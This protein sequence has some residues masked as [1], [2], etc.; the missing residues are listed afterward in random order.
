M[1]EPQYSYGSITLLLLFILFFPQLSNVFG[2]MF[3]RNESQ[4]IK[5]EHSPAAHTSLS[6][7]S[8]SREKARQFLESQYVQEAGL[9]RA[10]VTAKPDMERVYVAS[11]NLLAA[12]ALMLLRSPLGKSIL[13]KLA[14]NYGYGFNKRHE[15]I[16]GFD[17][18]DEFYVLED[19]KIGEVYSKEFGTT[20]ELRYE[21]P[22]Q[23]RV[24]TDWHSYADLLVYRALDQIIAGR[25][26]EAKELSGLLLTLWD[27]YGFNDKTHDVD[28]LKRYETYKVALALLLCRVL[29]ELNQECGATREL[30][31]MW[32]SILARMQ[33]SDGGVVTHYVVREGIIEPYGDA[34]TETTSIATLSLSELPSIFR[35]ESKL[36]LMQL[37]VTTDSDWTSVKI[38]SGPRVID[39]NGSI[40]VGFDAHDLKYSFSESHIWISKKQFDTTTVTFKMLSL[41][42]KGSELGRIIINKGHMGSTQVT[43]RLWDGEQFAHFITLKHAGVNWTEPKANP[44]FFTVNYSDLYAKPSTTAFYEPAPPSLRKKVCAFYY[45]WYGNPFGP[46]RMLSHW[47]NIA[48]DS[49]ASSAHYPLLGPY[50]SYDE[51]VIETHILMAKAAGIDCFIVSWWGP[52]S[53]EDSALRHIINVS[54]RVGFNITI[55]YE[56][57]REW[58]PLTRHEDVVYELSYLVKKYASSSSFLK[59]GSKPVLFIYNVDGHGRGVE[60]WLKVRQNLER[61]VGRVYIIG[62]LRS[63]FYLSVFDGFHTYNELNLTVMKDTFNFYKQQMR[64]GLAGID[65][66]QATSLVILRGNPTIQEKILG[67][68]VTP[69]YDDR[70]VRK[71]G[72]YLDRK[73][74][75]TYKSYW[76]SALEANPD[77]ILV[78]SWNE[79]HEGTEVEPSREYGFSYIQLTAEYAITFKGM[80]AVP[81]EAPTLQAEY[82]LSS[83]GRTLILKMTTNSTALIV[84]PEIPLQSS[85]HPMHMENYL[86]FTT[87]GDGFDV[88]G[89]IFP[90]LK[91][92]ETLE[93]RLKL[94]GL[95]PETITIPISHITYYST[96][97][98]KLVLKTVQERFNRLTI[99]SLEN[100]SIT[101]QATTHSL[102]DGNVSLWFREKTNVS[103]STKAIW[104]P[105]DFE[106]KKLTSYIVNG[107]EF[108]VHEPKEEFTLTITMYRPIEIEFRYMT[109]YYVWYK[110]VP[111]NIIN[112]IEAS[113]RESIRGGFFPSNKTIKI[114]LPPTLAVGNSTKYVFLNM[115]LELCIPSN[116]IEFTL[117]KPMTV[118]ITYTRMVR[119]DIFSEYGTVEGGGW[120]ETGSDVRISILPTETGFLIRKVFDHWE[121]EKGLPISSQPVIYIREIDKPVKFTAIWRTDYS[122]L[123]LLSITVAFI[124]LTSLAVKKRSRGRPA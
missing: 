92:G 44:R 11:D 103:V 111:E 94:T 86:T 21:K 45:P 7:Y 68:T 110:I 38:L 17:I 3:P 85:L 13:E 97:G 123:I 70:K 33:R 4:I 56:S 113:L 32:L 24:L 122:Q 109:E 14:V 66:N 71:P 63:Q 83:D 18:P 75:D 15:V 101:L 61:L 87:K 106:R 89:R 80:T 124:I 16:L 20:F 27:G 58:Q 30:L 107:K 90:L 48:A 118:T 52:G 35:P 117:N 29:T 25:V 96:D 79:W 98:R 59:A 6:I 22:N 116:E 46:S 36:Y 55:Y 121:D 53:F 81:I 5:V 10:A 49:I 23:S 2:T 84:T 76:N 114:T 119:V 91:P 88:M 62:D 69:G 39:Y 57:F 93:L 31:D 73:E 43:I 64:L 40:S 72:S 9:L 28:V 67:F 12:R 8:F 104:N 112:E 47:S 120:Y 100:S 41:A 1:A 19:E 77:I 74:G 51:R 78:T 105:N 37:E 82:L 102:K 95:L 26:K 34:N 65:L 99:K 50:D 54:E 115:C 60:F 42:V 108:M